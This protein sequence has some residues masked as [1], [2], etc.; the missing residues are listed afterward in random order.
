MG[1]EMPKTPKKCATCGGT[2]SILSHRS[3]FT[4]DGFKRSRCPI[5]SGTGL[6][7]YQPE[8][9]YARFQS[10]ARTWVINNNAASAS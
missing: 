3:W 2:G 6:S 4:A 7:S 8:P 5:C 10:N 9:G 1:D